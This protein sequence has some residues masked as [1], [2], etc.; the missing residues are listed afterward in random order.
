MQAITM[1]KKMS[2]THLVTVWMI[3]FILGT[4]PRN[5]KILK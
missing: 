2:V 4:S 3:E 5:L 1:K